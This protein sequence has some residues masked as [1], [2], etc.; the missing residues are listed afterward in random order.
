MC[1]HIF[2]E[3]PPV[4]LQPPFR[5]STPSHHRDGLCSPFSASVC[6]IGGI[7]ATTADQ[8]AYRI[9]G[10]LVVMEDR[11]SSGVSDRRLIDER[12]D[13]TAPHIPTDRERV[14]LH[15]RSS[16][17][18]GILPDILPPLSP[19]RRHPPPEHRPR[20]PARLRRTDTV[21]SGFDIGNSSRPHQLRYDRFSCVPL[22]RR[23]WVDRGCVWPAKHRS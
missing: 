13:H 15:R 1:S 19:P 14:A 16:Q 18:I 10:A 22:P 3:T 20:G 11:T 4:A 17:F 9:C 6:T 2:K 23:S 8:L 7:I 5:W 12:G 21:A